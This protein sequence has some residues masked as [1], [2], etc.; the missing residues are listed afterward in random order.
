MS[1]RDYYLI[2]T[3]ILR[4][5]SNCSI[6]GTYTYTHKLDFSNKVKI[7]IAGEEKKNGLFGMLKIRLVKRNLGEQQQLQNRFDNVM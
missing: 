7:E 2:S 5:D 6:V 3:Y 4:L 1:I